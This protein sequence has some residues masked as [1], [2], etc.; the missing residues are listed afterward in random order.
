MW[1]LFLPIVAVTTMVLVDAGP[2]DHQ[3]QDTVRALRLLK[4][5]RTF[6]DAALIIGVGLSTAALMNEPSCCMAPEIPA[7]CVR[8]LATAMA[9]FYHVSSISAATRIVI[10][11]YNWQLT[12]T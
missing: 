5:I 2:S 10:Y 9:Y 12:K 4:M 11:G 1:K 6:A 8:L 3:E 7:E